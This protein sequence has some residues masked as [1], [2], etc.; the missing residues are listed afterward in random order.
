MI[1]TTPLIIIEDDLDHKLLIK[2]ALESLQHQ[3]TA[4]FFDDPEIAFNFLIQTPIKPLIVL[5]NLDGLE[6]RRKLHQKGNLLSM[7]TPFILFT[8][9]LK[10]KYFTDVASQLIHGIFVKPTTLEGMR[11]L[12]KTTLD[13]WCNGSNSKNRRQ[14]STGR[15]LKQV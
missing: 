11:E 8:T 6:Y 1:P 15:F 14:P 12:L 10:Q 9:N 7:A 2:T 4:V 5:S 3:I 13:H